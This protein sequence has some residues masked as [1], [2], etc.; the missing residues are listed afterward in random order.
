MATCV[1]LGLTCAKPFTS[2]GIASPRFCFV[3][4]PFGPRKSGMP[5]AVEI[6]AL[7]RF[8]R[9]TRNERLIDT[10]LSLARACS[11]ETER[12]HADAP[13]EDG[14]ALRFGP[15]TR[16]QLRFLEQIFA[17]LEDLFVSEPSSEIF[18]TRQALRVSQRHLRKIGA[19]DEL[20]HVFRIPP[21]FFFPSS[22]K[23]DVSYLR[24]LFE[25]SARDVQGLLSFAKERE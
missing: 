2:F 6:P 11:K 20:F 25:R 18:S 10:S 1:K 7:M 4:M 3:Q 15:P 19:H 13:G 22:A 21:S 16:Q 12:E 8:V 24:L 23:K 5:H 17:R 9:Q 14:D